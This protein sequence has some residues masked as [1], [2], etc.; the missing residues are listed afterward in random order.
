LTVRVLSAAPRLR[1]CGVGFVPL[2]VPLIV[3]VGER[4]EGVVLSQRATWLSA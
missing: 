1:V 2:P 4:E 3:I